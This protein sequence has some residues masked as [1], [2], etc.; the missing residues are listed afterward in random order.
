[1]FIFNL[2]NKKSKGGR[3]LKLTNRN[4]EISQLYQSGRLS[5]NEIGKKY[6]ITRERIRQICVREIGKEKTS[7]VKED[8]TLNRIIKIHG[9]LENY[10][11][12][13]EVLEEKRLIKKKN[14][15]QW[16]VSWPCCQNCGTTKKKHAGHGY[17]SR[18][19]SL[20]KYHTSPIR[21]LQNKT[22][23]KKWRHN[24]LE[25]VKEKQK[26]YSKK[27]NQRPDIKEKNR[28]RQIEYYKK[29]DVAKKVKEYQKKYSK[30]PEVILRR[31]IQGQLK[32]LKLKSV[33]C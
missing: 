32:R 23:G 20:I 25:K 33:V 9:S 18:C 19:Y 11:K 24:N 27:Y 21:R 6:G 8:R 4:K 29:P 22:S 3:N 7:K 12:K 16:C 10:A 13:I 26:I 17:C 2:F 28:K 15:E 31:R 1:M 5:L 14:K 30:R